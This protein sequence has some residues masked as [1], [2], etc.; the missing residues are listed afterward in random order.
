M[1]YET[2]ISFKCPL[3][4]NGWTL[5]SGLKVST[6]IA[7]RRCVVPLVAQLVAGAKEVELVNVNNKIEFVQR[8]ECVQLLCR[9]VSPIHYSC[10]YEVNT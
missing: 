6:L 5:T 2:L 10:S 9:S 3:A 7:D 4:M 1:F 8:K